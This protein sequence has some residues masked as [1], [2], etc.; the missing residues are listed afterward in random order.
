MGGGVG[1]G[2]GYFLKLKNDVMGFVK[3][4]ST[5]VSNQ[6]W[7]LIISFSSFLG[8]GIQQFQNFSPL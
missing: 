6:S 1:G 4:Q 7:A 2:G 5:V 8:I 3:L